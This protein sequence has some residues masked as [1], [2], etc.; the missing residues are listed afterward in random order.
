MTHLGVFEG[1]G[2]FSLAARWMGWTTKAW[3]EINPFCQKVLRY[4]FPEA[5]GFFDI[6]NTSLIEYA[7]RIDVYTGGFPCQPYSTS[8]HRLGKNDARH[9]WPEMRRTYKEV[10]PVY[11]VGE[12]VRGLVNWNGGMVFDEVCTELEIDGYEVFP[13]LLPAAG[14]GAPHRR[15]RIFFVAYSHSNDAGRHRYEQ[16]GRTEG[17]S[18]IEQQE[19]ERVRPDLKRIIQEGTFANAKNN[20]CE[21]GKNLD[22]GNTGQFYKNER[23]GNQEDGGELIGRGPSTDTHGGGLQRIQNKEEGQFSINGNAWGQFPTQSGVCFGDDGIY[24]GLDADSIFEGIRPRNGKAFGK[25]RNE[26]IKAAGNAVVPQIAHQIFKAIEKHRKSC[27]P[28]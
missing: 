19:R 23:F 11:I 2:A 8:G 13:V 6:K 3:V 25:W 16:T 17:E 26:S 22:Y 24:A 5:E 12:N 28:N 4:H 27:P 18:K 15:E 9:L 14:V 1:I 7:N 10:Q 20:G 21:F